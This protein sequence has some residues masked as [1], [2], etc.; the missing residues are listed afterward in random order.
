VRGG[1]CGEIGIWW[2]NFLYRRRRGMMGVGKFWVG[3]SV[4]E[5]TEEEGDE[6]EDTLDHHSVF[7]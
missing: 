1:E 6:M 4:G 2:W 3:D 7:R 5:G